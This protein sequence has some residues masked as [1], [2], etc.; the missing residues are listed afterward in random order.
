MLL[1]CVIQFN[2]HKMRLY[3]SLIIFLF[4]GVF[5]LKSQ[6]INFGDSTIVSLIT[7]EPGEAIYAKFG[8]TAI[9]IRDTKGLDLVY[10]YGIFDFKTEKFYWKFLRGHTD[11]MLGVYPTEHFLQEYSERNSAVWE[12]ELNMTAI[13]RGRLIELLNINYLPENRM[14]RYN[15]VYDNCATRPYD[16]I[17]T[18]F[19]GVIVLGNEQEEVTFREMI[20]AYLTDNPW[21]EFGINLIFGMDADRK[22]HKQTSVFLP[23]YLRTSLQNS[24]LISLS[25]GV[26]EKNVVNRV[27]ILVQPKPA[28]VKN[29]V[30]F[31]HPFTISLIWLIIGVILIFAQKNL[32]NIQHKIFD[33]ILYLSTGLGGLLIFFFMFFSEH[34]LVGKSLNILWLSPINIILAVLIWKRSPRKFFFFYN[35]I[36]LFLMLLYILVTIFLTNSVVLA[37]IPLQMLLFLRVLWREERL[38]HILFIPTNKGIRWR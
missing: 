35:I 10:N 24:K 37:F 16:I 32:D 14:Y 36:Y 18:A 11:Y 19:N 28:D 27:N 1:L 2:H 33:F 5:G 26:G 23:E 38:L 13:E 7:C 20:V 22:V 31:F 6:T 30:W 21:T 12:Q 25:E 8:H 15:F 4:M 9:R 17:N 29:P 34:P 3:I